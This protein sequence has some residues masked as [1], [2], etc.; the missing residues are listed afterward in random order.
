M[1]C[2]PNTPAAGKEAL[3][4]VRDRV[5]PPASGRWG[6]KPLQ[7]DAGHFSG[8]LE[9]RPYM[10]ARLGLAHALWT[11]GRRDEAVGHLQDMLRLNPNDNQGV[12]YTLAGFLLFLDRDDELTRLLDQYG[13][14]ESAAW[15]YTSALLAFRRQGDTIE[16]RQSL[17]K[18]KKT[19]KHVPNY[20]L[21]RKFPPSEQ[22]DY[23][24]P[25]NE[26]EAL[27]YVGSFLA[28][29]KST[30]GAVAWLRANVEQAKKAGKAGSARGQGTA[31]LQSKKWLKDKLPQA[32]DVWQADFRR[33]PN[34]IRIG[35][36]HVR[37]WT[38]LVTSR[39]NDLVLAHQLQEETPSTAL[40][41]DT[42]VQAMQHPAAG[43]PHRPTELQ[44]R[45]DERWESL[46]PHFEEIGVELVVT[47]TNSTI[48]TPRLPRCANTSAGSLSRGCSTCLESRRN[49][50]LASTR[51]PRPSSRRR[52]G[53]KSASKRRYRWSATSS[54]AG[55]GTRSSWASPA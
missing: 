37:P 54:R 35:G 48:S 32:D 12:R 34:W 2:W 49:R 28:A 8:L 38:I 42:L 33:L 1:S 43:E 39:S 21:G 24:S 14:E 50:S 25:G 20:L 51:R 47:R 11:A 5:S 53:K 13:D 15:A 10:R 36:E 4:S 40:L 26:S 29:W 27:N 55:P 16:A 7:R 19:N 41:W 22:P 44:V 46:R 18:A 31:R 3:A 23:Y 17:K 9:T 52:R 6:R 45:P 30:P